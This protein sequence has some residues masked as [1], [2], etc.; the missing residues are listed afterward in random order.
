MLVPVEP[1]VLE[2]AKQ[3][4]AFLRI[5]QHFH[6]YFLLNEGCAETEQIWET[7]TKKLIKKAKKKKNPPKKS[8]GTFKRRLF[9]ILAKDGSSPNI[10]YGPL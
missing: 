1:E 4:K 7:S 3:N 8:N 6:F 2:L 5:F 10:T 9:P